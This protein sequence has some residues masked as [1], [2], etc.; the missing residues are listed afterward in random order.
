[1]PS[2]DD[3]PSH[4]WSNEELIQKEIKHRRKIAYFATGLVMTTAGGVATLG[5]TAALTTPIAAFKIYKIHSHLKKL[6]AVRAELAKRHLSPVEKRK[7]DVLIPMT[8]S[9]VLFL[10]TIGIADGLDLIP[11]TVPEI[12]EEA[13]QEA[14]EVTVSIAY[15]KLFLLHFERICICTELCVFMH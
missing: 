1:M 8:K 2:K 11:D 12:L 14:I 9:A 10:A 3:I 5:T 4:L 6:K 13:M 15:L 7:R